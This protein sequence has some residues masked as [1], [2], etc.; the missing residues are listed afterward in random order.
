MACC[1]KEFDMFCDIYRCGFLY[2]E[3]TKH[4]FF[5]FTIN[6]TEISHN[7]K[8][9]HITYRNY[10]IMIRDLN[11]KVCWLYTSYAISHYSLVNKITN[12]F[13]QIYNSHINYI[14][15]SNF[16]HIKSKLSR[17]YTQLSFQTFVYKFYIDCISL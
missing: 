7:N 10:I 9:C 12:M 15:K 6:K 3:M 1:H 13:K 17:S 4:F 8:L 5:F 16:F 11:K 14:H 2:L